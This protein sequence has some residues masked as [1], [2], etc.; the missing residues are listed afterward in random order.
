LSNPVRNSEKEHI[1]LSASLLARL[2]DAV[3]VRSRE[4]T[5]GAGHHAVPGIDRIRVHPQAKQDAFRSEPRKGQLPQ[6]LARE[7]RQAD[8]VR[9]HE[10]DGVCKR[11]LRG[12]VGD[13]AALVHHQLVP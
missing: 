3:C 1:P 5:R 12:E 10:V 7:E 6:V 8:H 9:S 4:Q 2:P 13:H 11:D